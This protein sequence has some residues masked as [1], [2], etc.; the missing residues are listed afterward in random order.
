MS[1]IVSQLLLKEVSEIPVPFLAWT[2]FTVS[3]QNPLIRT[4]D[5]TRHS[6]GVSRGEMKG[7]GYRKNIPL[8]GV[9]PPGG[10]DLLS[11]AVFL[12]A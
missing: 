11:C 2:L 1:E 7:T 9:P 6:G 3:C 8:F 10:L 5:C 12:R 4:G